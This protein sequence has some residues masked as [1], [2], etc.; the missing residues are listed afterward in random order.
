METASGP[1]P[2]YLVYFG[3]IIS[4]SNIASLRNNEP[5]KTRC[6]EYVF[7]SL[8]RGVQTTSRRQ[9]ILFALRREVVCSPRV[10][11]LVPRFSLLVSA[12]FERNENETKRERNQTRHAAL[13]LSPCLLS[14][15]CLFDEIDVRLINK[16]GD[17]K[18]VPQLYRSIFFTPFANQ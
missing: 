10:S 8:F 6:A 11:C 3:F 16:Q 9:L 13:L 14:A 18:R 7:V 12:F 17:N 5:K 15:Q 4:Y 1:H 2:A